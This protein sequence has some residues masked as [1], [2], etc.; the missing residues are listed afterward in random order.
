MDELLPD[1]NGIGEFSAKDHGNVTLCKTA[2]D[3]PGPKA[4]LSSR[5]DKKIRLSRPV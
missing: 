3:S 2:C 1:V 5:A 4:A